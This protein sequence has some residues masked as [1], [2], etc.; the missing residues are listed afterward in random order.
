MHLLHQASTRKQ[1]KGSKVGHRE[2]TSWE[3]PVPLLFPQPSE[4]ISACLRWNLKECE[5]H[6][7]TLKIKYFSDS[8]FVLL[9]AIGQKIWDFR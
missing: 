1:L 3:E 7:R 2:Q 8:D 4:F 6:R 9:A 5:T